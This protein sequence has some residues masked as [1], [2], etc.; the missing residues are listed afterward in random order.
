MQLIQAV[1]SLGLVVLCA[2]S[3]AHAVGSGREASAC[4]PVQ[5]SADAWR[6]ARERVRQLPELAS[7]G[8]EKLVLDTGKRE[9]IGGQCYDMVYVYAVNPGKDLDLLQVFAVNLASQI[10]RVEDI[11]SAEFISLETWRSRRAS[12]ESTSHTAH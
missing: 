7:W 4:R 12:G 3:S 8:G 1:G 9:R 11:P 10:I 5:S 6:R 2:L